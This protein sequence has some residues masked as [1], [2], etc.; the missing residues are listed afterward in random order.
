MVKVPAG[1]RRG[2]RAGEKRSRRSEPRRRRAENVI[3][4]GTTV[5]LSANRLLRGQLSD[6]QKR[7]W[8]VHVVSSPGE[9][10]TNAIQREKVRGHALP[11]RRDPAPL[12]DLVSLVRWTL[13][14]LRLRP[15]I[16]NVSTPKAALLG[17]IAAFATR[18]P[19]RIYVV[20]GLRLEGAVGR[21]RT[22]LTLMERL[23]IA[24]STDV[25]AVS[26]SLAEA[27]REEGLVQ[28]G[29]AVHVI[30]SGSSNGVDAVGVRTAGTPESRSALR[31]ELGI[32]DQ[33]VIGYLGRISTDKGIDSLAEATGLSPLASTSNWTLLCVGGVE[34]AATLAKLRDR[35][36]NL[37]HVDHTSEP[38]RYLSAMDILCLPTRREG[39][40]NVVLEAGALGIPTV[41]TNATGATDAVI[42]GITGLQVPVDDPAALSWALAELVTQP[43]QRS[44]MGASASL[45]V[46]QEFQQETIWDGLHTLYSDPS[47]QLRTRRATKAARH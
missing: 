37:V 25:I 36:E 40:P 43:S 17:S 18:V 3:V 11:M 46:D 21:A 26:H 5:G 29:T 16:T 45:R 20:R 13:L 6:M 41:T 9:D 12:R 38:W 14:L 35:V 4:Y 42:D 10:L 7:G 15:A 8:E 31:R 22:I 39:F 23:T 44:T 33:V 19:R 28:S 24:L 30:G 34:D 32:S 2:A 27:I 47:S 1:F